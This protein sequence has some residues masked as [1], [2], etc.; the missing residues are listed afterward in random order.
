MNSEH[1]IRQQYQMMLH[2]LS[3][4][5]LLLNLIPQLIQIQIAVVTNKILNKTK[6]CIIWFN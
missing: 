4:F 2:N 6:Y 3:Y 1:I 5:Q